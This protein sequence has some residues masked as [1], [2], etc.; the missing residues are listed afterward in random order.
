[1]QHPWSAS[2]RL[3]CEGVR[4][5]AGS[6]LQQS[7]MKSL[8]PDLTV[9]ATVVCRNVTCL[10]DGRHEASYEGRG[11]HR[12]VYRIGD[13]VMKLCTDAKET[14]FGSNRLEAE[15]LKKTKDL[16][17]TPRL[18]FEGKCIIESKQ[19]RSSQNHCITHTVNCL[20]MSYV[21]PSFDMLMHRCF[22]HPYN[23]TVANFF[24]SAYQE[25]GL[26]CIDGRYLK[27]AYSDLHTA[28]ISTLL[29]PARHV[30]GSSTCCVICDAEGVS[31][32]EYTRSVF[33]YCCDIMIADFQL[34]C[35][36][37]PDESWR[38]MA[39]S[40]SKFMHNFF[41]QHGNVEMDVL[42]DGFLKRFSLLWA[43]IC[44]EH[45]LRQPTA[46]Q[47]PP[48]Q[49]QAE[50]YAPIVSAK[51]QRAIQAAPW[52]SPRNA[53]QSPV[54]GDTGLPVAHTHD[55]TKE[56][57][58]GDE[59]SSAKHYAIA[60]VSAHEP[61]RIAAAPATAS[62]VAGHSV[63]APPPGS[64]PVP[65]R[66]P[67]EATV[68]RLAAVPDPAY[69][70]L[71]CGHRA[72]ARQPDCDVC[73]LLD[74]D[75]EAMV[76][77]LA[78]PIKMQIHA[79]MPLFEGPR[80]A[81]GHPVEH[82]DKGCLACQKHCADK[83]AVSRLVPGG[84]LK[85]STSR[86]SCG[87]SQK[88]YAGKDAVAS[89]SR[90]SISAPAH[91]AKTSARYRPFLCRHTQFQKGCM[92]CVERQARVNRTKSAASEMK[93]QQSVTPVTEDDAMSEVDWSDDQSTPA[94]PS[95]KRSSPFDVKE[96]KRSSPFDAREKQ[97][98]TLT[99]PM[100]FE[101]EDECY[102]A[103]VPAVSTNPRG[104]Y[105]QVRLVS[106]PQIGPA[107]LYAEPLS[108]VV[109]AEIEKQKSSK[110]RGVGKFQEE[111]EGRTCWDDRVTAQ[112][113]PRE[114]AMTRTQ[115]DDIGR[116]CKLMYVA[117]HNVLERCDM[118]PQGNK[119]RRVRI[120]SEF[121]KYHMA[122]R[123]FGYVSRFDF[124][125]HQWCSPKAVFEAVQMEFDHLCGY[126]DKQQYIYGFAFV[127]DYERLFLAT[128]FL[129]HGLS[130]GRSHDLAYRKA[131]LRPRAR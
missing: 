31:L 12:D 89:A 3:I 71:L 101:V 42:R 114:P 64:P 28:N 83:K 88:H 58:Q 119:Q 33:N 117:L 6:S 121:M 118:T 11:A 63:S 41:K 49:L 43:D 54:Q 21:G 74:A 100:T 30:P 45:H 53:A 92:V 52:H 106:R 123:I 5:E 77:E 72:N 109:A 25:L 69:G 40:I 102:D 120:E 97:T 111:R 99:G 116:L 86:L 70:R 130:H 55:E 4:A 90:V 68:P 1:M 124:T 112:N 56:A 47:Q 2:L 78:N 15:C 67:V 108:Q 13:I 75:S 79:S 38:F 23:H 104:D 8:I 125:E 35:N 19:H 62:V 73:K 24:V 16:E 128:S 96:A 66:S 81:C 44:K 36:L 17:Q 50:H 48:L 27:I 57:R 107:E 14:E 76:I 37:A 51:L 34:Q 84:S 22:G 95:R 59:A 91:P 115:S 7:S 85:S 39:V 122:K 61:T 32:G 18:L 29:D 103:G 113:F 129:A 98:S 87:A 9:S 10:S 60:T 127:D 94:V 126:Y 82:L 80:L 131:V 93:L 20:L 105:R 110:F 46:P 65:S 26:M